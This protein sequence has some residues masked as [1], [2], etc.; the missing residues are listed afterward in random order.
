MKENDI[1]KA[2]D[3]LEILEKIQQ[4]KSNTEKNKKNNGYDKNKN[5]KKR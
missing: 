5:K 4:R 2:R 3:R 1:E